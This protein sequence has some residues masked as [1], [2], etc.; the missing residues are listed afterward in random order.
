MRCLGALAVGLVLVALSA[1]VR[2]DESA[3]RP[4]SATDRSALVITAQGKLGTEVSKPKQLEADGEGEVTV[5]FANLA[6]GHATVVDG[7]SASLPRAIEFPMYVASGP[8]PRAAI[9]LFAESGR[10]LDPADADFRFGAIFRV[11]SMSS[12]RANDDGDNLFQRGLASEASMFKLEIGRDYPACTVKGA[13]GEVSVRSNIKI[14]P[15]AWYRAT[16]IRTATQV[17]IAVKPLQG[18]ETSTE[19]V[20]GA[21][22]RLSFPSDRFAAIGGKL[23]KSGNIVSGASDQFNGAIALVKCRRL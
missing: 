2:P 19:T 11:D 12:G 10:A 15:G 21:S 22:G 1:C 18:P 7:P 4:P 13:A 20:L 17:T 8:Y 9:R 16:C 23:Y 14:T 6:G 3:E 5:G